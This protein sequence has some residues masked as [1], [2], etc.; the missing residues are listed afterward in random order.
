MPELPEVETIVRQLDS[1]LEGREVKSVEVFKQKSFLGN[2]NLLI[3]KKI[4]K[5]ERKA[6]MILFEFVKWNKM[7]V[8][9]LKMTGQLVYLKKDGKRVIGGHAT[10][11]WVKELPSKH[12]RVVINFADGTKLFFNDLRIFG[13]MKIMENSKVKELIKNKA[14][15]VTEAEFTVDYLAKVLSRS[16]RAVKLMILDQDKMGGI[17]NIYACD[18]L[19]LAKV[20]PTRPAKSL[21]DKEIKLLHE[22]IIKVI[23]LGI[24]YGGATT[25]D[26][27]FVNA[28]GVGGKYQEHF[29]VYDQKGKKCQVCGSEILKIKLGG[30]GTYFCP[31]CQK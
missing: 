20:L 16:G 18:A 1:A 25:S 10:A 6:K 12:T 4:K 11:D 5:V 28:A 29:L 19:Y 3:G 21:T 9:H 17:G 27:R 14:P 26:D 15:D 8:V 7:M 22:S 30:R 13:W 31:T 2:E 23:N 24:K